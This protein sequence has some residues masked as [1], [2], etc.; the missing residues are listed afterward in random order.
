MTDPNLSN[1]YYNYPLLIKQ[2]L[3]SPL[4]WNPQQEIVGGLNK[5][6]NYKGFLNRINSLANAL[7]SIGVTKGNT[8]G[9][10]DWDCHRYLECFFAIPMMGAILHTI[11]IR[12]SE[13]QILYTINH[14][15]D[16]IIQN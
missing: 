13:Q 6:Y 8:I 12:L 11:N 7:K 10:M 14:A 15:E 3:F 1:S 16:D 2:L 9:V 5:K 4:A